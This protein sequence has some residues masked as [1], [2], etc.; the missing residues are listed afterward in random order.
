MGWLTPKNNPECLCDERP[1]ARVGDSGRVWRCNTC[2]RR[3]LVRV[4]HY[5]PWDVNPG[6]NATDVNWVAT[7]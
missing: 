4:T 1:R 2:G 3:W 7:T 5:E 6:E